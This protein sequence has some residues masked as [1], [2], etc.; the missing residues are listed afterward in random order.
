MRLLWKA[1][2]YGRHN[3]VKGVETMAPNTVQRMVSAAGN[4][5]G[6]VRT[7]MNVEERQA[8]ENILLAI[9]VLG[10]AFAVLSLSSKPA[11]TIKSP[12]LNIVGGA[13]CFVLLIISLLGGFLYFVVTGNSG[14]CVWAKSLLPWAVQ[15]YRSAVAIPVVFA[16]LAVILVGLFFLSKRISLI[17]YH[18]DKLIEWIPTIL[19][20]S[21]LIVWVVT[22]VLVLHSHSRAHAVPRTEVG[23]N[24]ETSPVVVTP[25][26]I[27][28][29]G[30]GNHVH[31]RRI[32]IPAGSYRMLPFT[33]SAATQTYTD[34]ERE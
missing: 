26:R 10:F 5:G 12:I 25:K 7:A 14:I 32:H 15:P 3:H 22:F 28:L 23:T 16:F 2:R 20:I 29:F 27:R 31:A 24:A 17:A 33:G 9:V 1:T 6:A 18:W 11:W 4:G 21:V 13:S 8:R 34:W 30:G 19:W